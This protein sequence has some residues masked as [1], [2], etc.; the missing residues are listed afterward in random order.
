[1]DRLGQPLV[2]RPIGEHER[3]R[4]ALLDG[5]FTRGFHTLAA[6]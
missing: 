1:M 5:E 2:G 6:N 4:L 3:Y